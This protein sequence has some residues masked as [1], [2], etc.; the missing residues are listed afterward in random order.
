MIEPGISLLL[1]KVDSKY[2]LVVAIAK[3]ARQICEGAN[4]LTEVTSDKS[5]TV[6]IHEMSEDKIAYVRTKGGIK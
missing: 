2:T 1:N 4:I 5:V 3:R 6:A